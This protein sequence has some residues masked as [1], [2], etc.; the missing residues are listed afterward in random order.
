[1]RRQALPVRGL[2]A[3]LPV[4]VETSPNLVIH[5][6][7]RESR[8]KE[9]GLPKREV[10]LQDVGNNSKCPALGDLKAMEQVYFEAP[11]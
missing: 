2:Q 11:I 8:G 10:R 4:P 9:T 1:M 3:T 7:I 6:C 5:A